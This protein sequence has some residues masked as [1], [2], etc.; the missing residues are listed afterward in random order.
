MRRC[1][2]CPERI[3]PGKRHEDIDDS[4]LLQ[5]MRPC[6]DH[7]GSDPGQTAG[8]GLHLL[9]GSMCPL[10][11]FLLG[12]EESI[13]LVAFKASQKD[14]GNT[15]DGRNPA[16]SLLQGSLGGAG[17]CPATVAGPLKQDSPK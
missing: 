13:S 10:S 9:R 8:V 6:G 17:F 4:E 16:P 5:S 14:T 1:E 15:V 3:Q 7:R 12:G 2:W 11:S